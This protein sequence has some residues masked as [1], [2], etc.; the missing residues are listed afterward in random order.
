M[1]IACEFEEDA[2]QQA[3]DVSLS[4]ST[5]IFT[6]PG[7]V[8]ES[9]LGYDAAFFL[10]PSNHLNLVRKIAYRRTAR[11]LRLHGVN[12]TDEF[13]DDLSKLSKNPPK[14]KLNLF[15]QYKVP[16][17]MV[18]DK[19]KEWSFWKS[20]YY[21]YKIRQ[22]QLEILC[23]LE[24]KS[25]GRAIV[26]YASPAFISSDLLE[27]FVQSGTILDNSNFVSAGRL[28][29]HHVYSYQAALCT[30]WAHSAAEEVSPLAMRQ[31]ISER[32]EQ[33][34]GQTLP[35]AVANVVGV[36]LDTDWGKSIYERGEES[37]T[38]PGFLE[39]IEIIQKYER[40]SG[41]KLYLLG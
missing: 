26:C 22:K 11:Y 38:P 8:S 39:D 5:N 24:E 25:A 16:E 41:T 2:F 33:D 15:V 30:G 37:G 34:G 14:F 27:S 13:F 7:R 3:L 36:I 10:D 9:I 23:N 28:K 32:I 12:I 1:S 40:Y 20:D 21:R 18:G 19:A 31:V 17:K 4:K 6:T 35:E 29:G